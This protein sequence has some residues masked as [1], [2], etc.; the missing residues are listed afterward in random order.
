MAATLGTIREDTVHGR[1]RMGLKMRVFPFTG[2][3]DTDTWASGI[4]GI[5]FV[6]WESGTADN[7]IRAYLS[8][9]ATGTITF[10]T[11]GA[12]SYAG[13]VIVWSRS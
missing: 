9:V 7:F 1:S 2:V 4:D 6:A 12:T 13:N 5:Q 10:Q 11:D 3:S 8:A